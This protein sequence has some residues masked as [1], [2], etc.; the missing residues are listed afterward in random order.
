MVAYCVSVDDDI[1]TI[2]QRPSRGASPQKL[3][4]GLALACI[5]LACGSILYTN[6]AGDRVD[7]IVTPPKVTIVTAQPAAPAKPAAPKAARAKSAKPEFF[8]APSFDVTFLDGNAAM[9][10]V[11]FSRERPTKLALHAFRLDR[12][13]AAAPTR[14][15]ASVLLPLPRPAELAQLTTA[16]IPPAPAPREKIAMATASAG[17]FDQLFG[18]RDTDLTMAYAPAGFT[19]PLR[20]S[21]T[22]MWASAIQRSGRT[23]AL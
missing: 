14:V 9:P 22:S 8:F 20:Q 7:D 2:G 6:L 5:A 23:A 11:T 3:L 13:P 10:L 16:S 17:P 4:G 21:M 19:S 18:K 12:A 1:P 15:L